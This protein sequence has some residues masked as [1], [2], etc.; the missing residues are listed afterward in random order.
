MPDVTRLGD[1]STGHGSF[2]PQPSIAASSKVLASGKGVVRQGD[3]YAVHSN[4]SSSHGGVAQTGSSKVLVSGKQ[5][6][7]VGDPINCGSSV[8]VGTPKVKAG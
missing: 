7:R 8:M 2:P 4:G 1:L 6:M 3:A 5:I